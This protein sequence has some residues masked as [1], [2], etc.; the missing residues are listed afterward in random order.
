M[1]PYETKPAGISRGCTVHPS[2]S[3]EHFFSEPFQEESAEWPAEGVSSACYGCCSASQGV[4][5]RP[6][7]VFTDAKMDGGDEGCTALK[8]WELA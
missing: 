3:K 7:C 4:C 2:I 5:C 1:G 6:S 8:I